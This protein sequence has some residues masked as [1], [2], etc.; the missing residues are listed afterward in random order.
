MLESG[1]SSDVGGS[2]PGWRR[3]SAL[4]VVGSLITVTVV[5]AGLYYLL[6]NSEGP[7]STPECSLLTR[8]NGDYSYM[9]SNLTAQCSW[10]NVEIRLVN[11]TNRGMQWIWNPM[12]EEL[13]DPTFGSVTETFIAAGMWDETTSPPSCEITDGNG[14]GAMDNGDFFS[15]NLTECTF[16]IAYD[17]EITLLYQVT[18]YPIATYSF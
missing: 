4:I 16:G 18:G 10:T 7:V 17:Y 9:I 8:S 13:Y 14:N 3:H 11:N 2:R 15:L 1:M 6:S 12:S 5:G